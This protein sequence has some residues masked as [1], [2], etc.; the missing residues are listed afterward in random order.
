MV[1]L[2]AVLAKLGIAKPQLIFS[3]V[4]HL[5]T[6]IAVRRSAANDECFHDTLFS[7]LDAPS[8]L[9]IHRGGLRDGR[10]GVRD[11]AGEIE[12]GSAPRAI[13]YETT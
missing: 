5:L 6:P 2:D 4:T 7:A 12:L 9:E 3:Q 10:I 8:H 1:S 13:G 11:I